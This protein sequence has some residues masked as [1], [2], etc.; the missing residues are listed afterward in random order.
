MHRLTQG[1][2]RLG[3]AADHVGDHTLALQPGLQ[4]SREIGIIFDQEN[5]HR[6]LGNRKRS[7]S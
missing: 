2:R 6:G 1:E 3:Q 5:A 4:G 7:R